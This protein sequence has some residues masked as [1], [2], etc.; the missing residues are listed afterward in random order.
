MKTRCKDCRTIIEYGKTRCPEC[1]HKLVKRN[2]D[3]LKDKEAEK[4]IKSSRWQ[5]VRKQILL[6]DKCCLL[7]LQKGILEYRKLSVH[8]IVKRT[9]N[10]ELMY[11]P[12]NLVTVCPKCHEEL[13]KL[14]PKKQQQLLK[15]ERKEI[16]FYL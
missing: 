16:E 3:S 2:K 1:Q 10:I 7:C 13:E 4:L 14:P 8:H 6:R 5:K 9:D 11:E 12:S 15:L